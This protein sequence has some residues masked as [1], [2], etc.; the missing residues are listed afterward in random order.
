MILIKGHFTTADLTDKQRRFAQ[1]YVVDF[2]ATQAATRAG[3]SSTNT[4]Y[5]T[6][7]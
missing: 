6:K 4:V 1:E 5:V 3:Y 7:L 2:N